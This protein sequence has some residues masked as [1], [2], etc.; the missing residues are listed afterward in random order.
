MPSGD[1]QLKGPAK[2]GNAVLLPVDARTLVIPKSKKG[3]TGLAGQANIWYADE[4]KGEAVVQEVH[5]WIENWSTRNPARN[6]KTRRKR[7]INDPEHNAKVEVAAVGQVREQLS[8][9]G[10][11]VCSVERDNVGWDLEA[12]LANKVRLRVEV[13]GL[14][15]KEPR[16]GLTP[17]EF[18]V[19]KNGVKGYRLAIV[20]RALSDSPKLRICRFS[21]E[22]G[23]WLVDGQGGCEVQIEERVSATV[24]VTRQ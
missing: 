24:R 13:K 1:F 8:E 21:D 22:R 20:T 10:Y 16:V 3:E 7:S 11:V 5:D 9:I 18:D 14:S 6:V 23:K 12:K 4:P 17:N 2:S 19:F 15:G